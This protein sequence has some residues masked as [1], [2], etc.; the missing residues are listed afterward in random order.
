MQPTSPTQP[1]AQQPPPQYP[2]YQY[3]P[4]PGYYAQPPVAPVPP[5]PQGHGLR[6][7][8][9][10]VVVLVVVLAIVVALE[11]RSSTWYI[12]VTSNHITNMVTYIVTVD[13]RQVDSGTLNPGQSVQ[14]TVPLTWWVDN[15]QSHSV[16]G[17]STG[18]GLGSETDSATSIICSGVPAS[19]DLSI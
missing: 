6:N 14:D 9:I 15:C 1:P 4:P 3:P 18:G 19:T 2:Q 8:A 12:T 7:V 13:G 5:P 16:V 11:Y 17:I 10:I